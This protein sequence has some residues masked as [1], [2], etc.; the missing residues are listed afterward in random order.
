[1]HAKNRQHFPLP[2]YQGPSLPVIFPCRG[3]GVSMDEHDVWERIREFWPRKL[4]FQGDA[5]DAFRGILR[6]FETYRGR[7]M[8]W[9]SRYWGHICGLPVMSWSDV[10]SKAAV[11]HSLRWNISLQPIKRRTIFPS[12][13]WLGWEPLAS[14]EGSLGPF[15][16]GRASF[17]RLFRATSFS[18]HFNDGHHFTWPDDG[19]TYENGLVEIPRSLDP[20][21]L[22]VHGWV[23][24]LRVP[25]DDPASAS[26]G[27]TGR[28]PPLCFGLME[29]PYYEFVGLCH[30]ARQV[31]WPKEENQSGHLISCWIMSWS[32][33]KS[34]SEG[35]FKFQFQVLALK[36]TSKPCIF[37]RLGSLECGTGL[38]IGRELGREQEHELAEKF[39]WQLCE[40]WIK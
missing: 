5:L 17:I 39:S 9:R 27:E 38:D 15:P 32:I 8:K 40:L 28:R 13:T 6:A 25:K 1:M 36:P 14:S 37:E 31:D 2:E 10:S 26:D 7:N 33:L 34:G 18:L 22:R 29:V 30:R 12:W 35:S 4:S 11:I 3:I 16:S 19:Y 24:E 20:Q 23:W 21:L